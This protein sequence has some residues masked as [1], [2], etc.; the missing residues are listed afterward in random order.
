MRL[1][2]VGS[3]KESRSAGNQLGSTKT[4]RFS[5]IRKPYRL[6]IEVGVLVQ[7]GKAE[8]N[9]L[10]RI[11]DPPANSIMNLGDHL[12]GSAFSHRNNNAY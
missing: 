6:C 10:W 12:S 5:G 11:E 1:A 8:V 2:S 9:I 7:R 4:G 3:I